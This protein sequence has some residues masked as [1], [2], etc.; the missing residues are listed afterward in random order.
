MS[1]DSR[2]EYFRERR[3]SIGQLNVSVPKEKLAALESALRV[4]GVTKTAWVNEKI[5]EELKKSD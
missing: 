5:D 4:K 1:Q 2:S 3:K